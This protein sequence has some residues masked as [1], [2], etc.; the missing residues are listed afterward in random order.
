MQYEWR[1]DVCGGGLALGLFIDNWG[2][3]FV[4]EFQADAHATKIKMSII[5]NASGCGRDYRL[6]TVEWPPRI[7]KSRYRF[8]GECDRR[9]V[10]LTWIGFGADKRSGETQAFA[11]VRLESGG[12]VRVDGRRCLAGFP[13]GAISDGTCHHLADTA[14]AQFR[15]IRIVIVV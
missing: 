3:M 1:K 6:S 5:H 8:D 10:I 7:A 14:T 13:L 4:D 11:A 15:T 12:C 2:P 9:H